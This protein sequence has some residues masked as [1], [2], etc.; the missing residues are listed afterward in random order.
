M[1][2]LPEAI[3]RPDAHHICIDAEAEMEQQS[4]KTMTESSSEFESLSS[5]WIDT[6]RNL[7][8]PLNKTSSIAI[9]WDPK[10]FFH[11]PPNTVS[12]MSL[13]K[14]FAYYFD[15]LNFFFS[16]IAP[17]M[18]TDFCERTAYGGDGSSFLRGFISEKFHRRIIFGSDR[19]VAFNK[20][21][22]TWHSDHVDWIIIFGGV[23]GL[24][25]L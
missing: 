23:R 16:S 25:D 10:S 8:F 12:P 11:S 7:N 21:L 14:L 15:T 1:D 18:K 24:G 5:L 6:N 19:T 4:P 3:I 17:E 22:L 13:L 9:G 20:V 2:S